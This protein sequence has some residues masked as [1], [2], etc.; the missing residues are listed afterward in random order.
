[1]RRIDRARQER[2]ANKIKREL[3]NMRTKPWK[4]VY[5][6]KENCPKAE[7]CHHKL[8]FEG[9]KDRD[10]VIE[11]LNPYLQTD[12]ECPHYRTPG[13]KKTMAVGFMRQVCRMNA[14]MLKKFQSACMRAFCKTVY[15]EMRAGN[16]LLSPGEQSTIRSCAE[17]VGWN[18]PEN[19]FDHMYEVPVW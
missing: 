6:L 11:V 19:G 1:M 2:M 18:F 16:R 15:Y 7:T 10:T 14:D 17:K 13:C 9:H 12:G 3:E 8:F 4:Y 5:C